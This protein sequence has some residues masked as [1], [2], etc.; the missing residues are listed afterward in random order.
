M[1]ELTWMLKLT[2]EGDR[3]VADSVPGQCEFVETDHLGKAEVVLLFHTAYDNFIVL[4]YVDGHVG[5][6][7]FTALSE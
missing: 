3:Y 5:E 4:K 7:R 6:Y 2:W 1:L